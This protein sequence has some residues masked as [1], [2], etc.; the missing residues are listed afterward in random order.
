M[1]FAGGNSQTETAD[2]LLI[3]NDNM[4]IIDLEFVH[5][6][7]RKYRLNWGDCERIRPV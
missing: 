1:D 3:A 4:K 7:D 6:A 2:D 5:Q